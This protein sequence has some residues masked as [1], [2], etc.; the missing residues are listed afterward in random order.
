MLQLML[1]HVSMGRPEQIALN[2]FGCFGYIFQVVSGPETESLNMVISMISN[3]MAAF[4]HHP[5]NIRMLPHIIANAEKSGFDVI[6]IQQIQYPWSDFRNRSVIESEV[7]TFFLSLDTPDCSRKEYPVN[8]W[9]L[10]D[11][12]NSNYEL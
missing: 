6:G 5:V 1:P 7:Y 3:L 10:F 4:Q 2:P 9:G 11:K 12:H 8:P